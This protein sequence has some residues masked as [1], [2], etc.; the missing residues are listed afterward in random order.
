MVG[1]H[2][3]DNKWRKQH[4]TW[5]ERC[6]TVHQVN[7]P[8]LYTRLVV[9]WKWYTLG[10]YGRDR[11]PE[12]IIRSGLCL[13][14]ALPSIFLRD[15]A[16][17]PPRPLLICIYIFHPHHSHHPIIFRDA[18]GRKISA[19]AQSVRVY[20]SHSLCTELQVSYFES[21]SLPVSRNFQFEPWVSYLDRGLQ[22]VSSIDHVLSFNLEN[23]TRLISTEQGISRS[24]WAYWMGPDG[25]ERKDGMKEEHQYTVERRWIKERV[26]YQNY[27]VH[28]YCVLRCTLPVR[29]VLGGWVLSYVTWERT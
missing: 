15:A 9:E 19:I 29:T 5:R 16:H 2:A 22:L 1:V 28:V 10:I 12:S 14:G 8:G 25:K 23:S 26:R 17:I 3:V 11:L 24:V 6:S 13:L 4:K 7:G 18:I 20:S 21:A 27:E